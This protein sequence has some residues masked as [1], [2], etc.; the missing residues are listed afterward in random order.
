MNSAARDKGMEVS[1]NTH[2]QEFHDFSPQPRKRRTE[3]SRGWNS[4]DDFDW[5]MD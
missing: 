5:L 3:Q 1:R 2:D 4:V